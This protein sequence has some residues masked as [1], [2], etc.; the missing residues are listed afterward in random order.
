M[1][2]EDIDV[3]LAY[4]RGV[5]DALTSMIATCSPASA[6]AITEWVNTDLSAWTGGEPPPAPLDWISEGD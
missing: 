1:A 6:A 3:R 2:Y 5:Q 4:I